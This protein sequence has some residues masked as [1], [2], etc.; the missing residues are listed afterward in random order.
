MKRVFSA[1][2]FNQINDFAKYI[3]CYYFMCFG[4][5]LKKEKKKYS[6]SLFS[7]D[8]PISN[9]TIKYVKNVNNIQC[10]PKPISMF[11]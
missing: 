1:K 4:C 2:K 10:I 7:I 6:V 11:L 3:I 8:V 5:Y 9:F